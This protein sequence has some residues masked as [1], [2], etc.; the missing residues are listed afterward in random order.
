MEVTGALPPA[1]ELKEQRL[2]SEIVL[3]FMGNLPLLGYSRKPPLK[4]FIPPVSQQC[5]LK[6]LCY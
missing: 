5:S 1:L 6:K 4:S 2:G 3:G